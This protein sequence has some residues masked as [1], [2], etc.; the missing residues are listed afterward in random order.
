MSYYFDVLLH[1]KESAALDDWTSKLTLV[2]STFKLGSRAFLHDLAARTVEIRRNW[3]RTYLADCPD[4]NS[5]SSAVKIFTTAFQSCLSIP[6][7]LSLLRKWNGCLSESLKSWN[8]E[9]LDRKS[10]PK[11]MPSFSDIMPH[12]EYHSPIGVIILYVSQLLDV[13]PQMWRNAYD[14]FEFIKDI[15][16]LDDKEYCV[17]S[18]V[19]E[20]DTPARL[21]CLILRDH[22]P[23]YLK[24]LFPRAS[25]SPDMVRNLVKAE[26]K[27]QPTPLQPVTADTAMNQIDSNMA[28]VLDIL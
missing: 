3:I 25:L 20:S 8:M 22:T 21:V 9:S 2:L 5:R 4:D 15:S 18:A 28:A 10:S 16:S 7:E 27:A 12:M 23:Q 13:A 19:T 26:V 1:Y 17:L 11:P 6:L 24:V 14:L